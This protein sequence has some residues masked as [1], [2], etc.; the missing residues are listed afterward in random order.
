M[1]S[2]SNALIAAALFLGAIPAVHAHPGLE[3]AT[4]FAGGLAHPFSGW[5]HLLAMIAVGFWAAQLRAPRL[6]PAAFLAAMTLGAL[7]GHWTGPVPG[8]EQGV[9]ASVLV[10]GLLIARRV[11][12]PAAAGAAWVGVFAI[13][14]GAAHGAEMP[15]TAGALA[16]GCGFVAATAILLAAGAAAG[17]LAELLPERASRTPGWVVAAAGLALLAMSAGIKP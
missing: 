4:G 11:R 3:P 9:A 13:F 2:R 15:A 16:Y 10:L 5:D 17:N 6:L 7:A 12:V 1:K 14:H 8:L